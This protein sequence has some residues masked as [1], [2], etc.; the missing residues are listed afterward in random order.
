MGSHAEGAP[1]TAPP[2]PAA[3]AGWYWTPGSD[4]QRYWDGRSWT[5]RFGP[6]AAAPLATV[7]A[8]GRVGSSYAWVLAAFTI[9]GF[10]LLIQLLRVFGEPGVVPFALIAFAV[11]YNASKRDERQLLGA[12]YVPL[13]R[14]AWVIPAV[15][16][17]LRWMRTREGAPW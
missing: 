11:I 4:R 12:G 3:P 6:P 13:P 2:P 17:T 5:H 14:L 9:V 15:Y 16:L 10:P 7:A 1:A 8:P